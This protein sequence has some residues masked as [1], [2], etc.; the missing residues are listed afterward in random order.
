MNT[1]KGFQSVDTHKEKRMRKSTY[2]PKGCDYQGRLID[3]E[4]VFPAEASSE[5]LEDQTQSAGPWPL[6]CI[7]AGTIVCALLVWQGWLFF[8]NWIG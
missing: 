2:I 3:G 5:L 7:I 4:L 1:H 8:K 6:V